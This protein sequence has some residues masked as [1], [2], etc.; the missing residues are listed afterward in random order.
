MVDAPQQLRIVTGITAVPMGILL[1]AAIAL[2]LLSDRLF[3]EAQASNAEL[4]TLGTLVMAQFLLVVLAGAT[5][6]GA[7]LRYSHRVVGPAQRLANAIRSV[8]EGD[9]TVQVVL[10]Q[11]DEMQAIARELNA[12]VAELRRRATAAGQAEIPEAPPACSNETAAAAGERTD[13]AC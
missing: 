1:F 10:R 13:D 11:G 4:P 2:W 6:I 12:L 5:A 9:T 8:R 7:A 3:D